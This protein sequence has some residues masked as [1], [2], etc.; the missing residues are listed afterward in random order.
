M[1]LTSVWRVEVGRIVF[2]AKTG[3]FPQNIAYFFE[4]AGLKGLTD[5]IPVFFI[6]TDGFFGMLRDLGFGICKKGLYLANCRVQNLLLNENLAGL[7]DDEVWDL[8]GGEDAHIKWI[9]RIYCGNY[10]SV[11]YFCFSVSFRFLSDSSF[12]QVDLENGLA[13]GKL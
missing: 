5:Q 2:G 9:L 7:I 1:N 12:S 10:Q 3:G 11:D 8:N 6:K 13:C 4:L